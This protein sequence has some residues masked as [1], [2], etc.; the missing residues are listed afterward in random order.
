MIRK[1]GWEEPGPQLLFSSLLPVSSERVCVC[2]G[3]AQWL[4]YGQINCFYCLVFFSVNGAGCFN[5]HPHCLP[6]VP[7]RAA[8][9]A[10]FQSV[11]EAHRS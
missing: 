4:V 11:A 2:V 5:E 8:P 9:A 3:Q 1:M 10:A 6:A 7:R